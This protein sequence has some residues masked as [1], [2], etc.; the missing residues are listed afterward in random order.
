MIFLLLL[1]AALVYLALCALAGIVK[2][3]CGALIVWWRWK[4]GTL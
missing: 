1:C 3:V 2:G 4:R